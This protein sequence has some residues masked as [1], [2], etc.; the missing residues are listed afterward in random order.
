MLVSSLFMVFDSIFVGKFVGTTAFAALGLGMPMIIVNFALSDL[1][2]VGSSVII[3]ILLGKKEENRANNCF[4][5]A[6]IM[7]LITGLVVGIA[8]F[9]FSPVFMRLM[10][11]EG[12]LASLGVQYIRIYALF[13]PFTTMTFSLDNYL[14]ICGKIKTSMFLNILMTIGTVLF[15]SILILGFDMGIAGA[16]LGANI[17]FF[18]FV[19]AGLSMFLGRKLQL[20]FVKPSFSF[21]L[22]LQIFKN[23][24][25]AFLTN[26]AGRIFSIAMNIMLL[27]MGG[28]A[29]VAIYGVLMTVGG[30]VEQI[31]Y[32][33]LDSLQPAIGYNYGAERIDRVKEIERYCLTTGAII[34]VLFAII[35]F[36]IPGFIAFPFLEDLSLLTLAKHALRLFSFTYLFKWMGHSVQSFLMALERPM[37]ATI[38]SLSSAFVFPFIL[39][40]TLLPLE[41]DG[42]WLN[43]TVTSFLTAILSIVIILKIKKKLFYRYPYRKENID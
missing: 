20:K 1:I 35:I 37:P 42:L 14:R 7:T 28:E 41:L 36:S 16:A 17:S 13:S 12:E 4:T 25:P 30:V 40:S 24:S 11:A 21:K 38:I 19:I 9:F 29:A 31:L 10:G 32:G 5:C 34:S 33:V 39:I 26:V 27:K 43:Y 22:V 8:F 2:G 15:E 18:L 3:S 6:T 23:G